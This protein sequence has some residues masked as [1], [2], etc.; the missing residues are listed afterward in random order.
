VGARPALL[1]AD[2][3]ERVAADLGAAI[4]E[5]ADDGLEVAILAVAHC[6]EEGD[7]VERPI[8]LL[9]AGQVDLNRRRGRARGRRRSQEDLVRVDVVARA[10]RQRARDQRGR[11]R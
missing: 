11:P 8:G 7:V 3:N 1:D 2:A 4:G 6:L 9:L 10:Q 5:R